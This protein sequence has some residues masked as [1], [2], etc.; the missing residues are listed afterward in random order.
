MI[1]LPK[2]LASIIQKAASKALPIIT[3]KFIVTSEHNK[4]WDYTS[5]TMIKI[6]NAHKKDGLQGLYSCQ[7]MS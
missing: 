3:D 7:D 2:H 4:N 1:P 5:P 6:Y